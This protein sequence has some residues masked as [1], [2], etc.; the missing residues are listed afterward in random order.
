[1]R[2]GA[3]LSIAKGT[4]ELVVE[5]ND[6]LGAYNKL[7]SMQF[8]WNDP[9]HQ[10]IPK[11]YMTNQNVWDSLMKLDYARVVKRYTYLQ[12]PMIMGYDF[13]QSDRISIG[14]RVGPVMS[15]LLASKQLSGAYDPGEKRIV[16]INS[17][18]PEQV[19]LN[20][21]VM[22]G[23]HTSIRLTRELQFEIE[24]SIRYYFNSVYE[25]PV[26]NAKPW[27]IGIRAAFVVK[28]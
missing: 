25:K 13:W 20:W 9:T 6:F 10:Y 1:M 8:T 18:A 27:S 11:F 12:I 22:A 24:P 26:N 23:L 4:N 19:S 14:V 2:T 17:I 21:Q 5:Y 16:S 28:F 7:D 3:G 15:I